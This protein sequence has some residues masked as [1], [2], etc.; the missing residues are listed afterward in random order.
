VDCEWRRET[1]QG[2]F[3][4]AP[5]LGSPLAPREESELF[6]SRVVVESQVLFPLAEREGYLEADGNTARENYKKWRFSTGKTMSSLWPLQTFDPQTEF[7]VIERKLPHWS[8]AGTMCFISFRTFDSIPEHALRRWHVERS[9]WLQRYGI[10]SKS[11]NWRDALM[12]LDRPIRGEFTRRFSREW[13]RNLDGCHG[14][15]V[16]RDP[17]LAKIVADSLLH[18]DGDRYSMSD[19]VVMPNHV[20]LLAAFE[21][22]ERMLTQCDS[23]KHFTA[24]Q[25]NLRLGTNGRFWQQDGFDH[26]VRSVEHFEAFRR[27]IAVNPSKAKL[28][29]GEY[30]LYSSTPQ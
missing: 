30:Y 11:E 28:K 1:C 3:G 25:I 4:G 16:L 10:D 13:H 17:E 20:H 15:C 23:W 12:K 6:S 21:D 24:R 26:L 2:E 5:A 18:F 27:Y 8:Q 7:A 29:H 9:E 14:A 19:F 22:E